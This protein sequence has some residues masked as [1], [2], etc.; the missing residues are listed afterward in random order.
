MHA[1]GLYALEKEDATGQGRL[2]L[3][4]RNW[5]TVRQDPPAG[6]KVSPDTTITLYAKRT[7]SGVSM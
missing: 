3:Y 5:T 6:A 7:R 4:D 1:A 2:L